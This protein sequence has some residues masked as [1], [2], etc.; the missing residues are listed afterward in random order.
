VGMLLFESV[1]YRGFAQKVFADLSLYG[2]PGAIAVSLL[3]LL[4]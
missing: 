3:L 4:V 2:T 1:G